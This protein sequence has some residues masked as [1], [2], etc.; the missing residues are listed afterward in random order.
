MHNQRVRGDGEGKVVICS[1][2]FRYQI[3]EQWMGKQPDAAEEEN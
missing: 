1:R 2:G 3:C